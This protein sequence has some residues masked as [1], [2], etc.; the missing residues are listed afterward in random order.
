LLLSFAL[1]Q[2]VLPARYPSVFFLGA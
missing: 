2:F 1:H